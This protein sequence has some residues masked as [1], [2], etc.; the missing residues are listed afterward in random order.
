M[1]RKTITR[2]G[3][4]ALTVVVVASGAR[5]AAAAFENVAVSPRARAM[6]ESAVATPEAAFAV[7]HNPAALGDATGTALAATYV[8]PFGLEFARLAYLSAA[9]PLPGAPGHLGLAFSDFAVERDDVDLMQETVVSLGYGVPLFQDLHST[10]ILG[11][12]A[13]LYRLEFAETIG[14]GTPAYEG[15]FDPGSASTL[16]LDVGLLAVLRERTRFGVL[17][18]NLNSPEIGDDQE[19]LPRRLHGG[20]AYEP[21]VGVVT[22]FEITAEVDQEA[23]YHGGLEFEL[24]PGFDLRAGVVTNPSK[25]TAGF[26]YAMRGVAL[27]YGFSTGGGVLDTTH[28]FGLT[29]AWGGES[30]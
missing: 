23:Q 1:T 8:Q 25:L 13:N 29:L 19:L 28:Q 11:A 24:A 10:V 5:P 4:L 17:V 6:G 2:C 18:H 20:V 9:I 3:L 30:K 27:N 16:G 15:A 14:D 7:A 12:S 22:S 26:G 21:Y